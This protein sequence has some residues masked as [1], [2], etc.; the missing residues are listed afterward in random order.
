MVEEKSYE[1]QKVM[2]N[3]DGY[4]NL[5]NKPVSINSCSH[6]EVNCASKPGKLE[7]MLQ[8]ISSVQDLGSWKVSKN[9]EWW[10]ANKKSFLKPVLTYTITQI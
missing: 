10:E 1:L 4:M 5:I 3:T 7:H 9:P 2:P 8:L 6:I